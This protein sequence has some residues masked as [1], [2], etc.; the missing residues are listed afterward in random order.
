MLAG[1]M[2][3]FVS[4]HVTGPLGAIRSAMLKLAGGDFEVV[5]PGLDRKDEI[6]AVAN[7]VE[8][9]KV[10]AVDKAHNE[11]D[12]AMARQKADADRH[13]EAARAEA[14]AQAK[15]RKNKPMLSMRSAEPSASSPR[16]ISP[17][18]S[19]RISPRPTRR[20]ATISISQS[21]AC[22]RPS[23]RLRMR[24]AKSA[25]RQSRFRPPPTT[26]RS[27]SKSRRRAS[28]RPRRRWKRSLRP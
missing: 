3:F 6:G 12:A 16:A 9:V 23:R 24:P 15:R 27:V 19:T 8:R 10:L 7:A 13:A 5:L 4:R 1:G 11:A 18:A 17:S 28:K 22:T 2:M 21:A 20:S 25:M 26:C 14:D